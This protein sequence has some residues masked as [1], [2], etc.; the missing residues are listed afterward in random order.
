MK[1]LLLVSILALFAI[2]VLSQTRITVSKEYRDKGC[3]K[4][5]A[6]SETTNLSLESQMPGDEKNFYEYET[7]IIGNTYYD[8][9][10]N[11][12]SQNRMFLYPDGFIGGTFTLG[13]DFPAFLSDRGTGYNKY[14]ADSWGPWPVARIEQDRCGWPCYAPWGS[15]GEIIVAHY[16]G[17]GT[18]G[19]VFSKRTTKGTGNW[20]QFDFT[21]PDGHALLW[22]RM[23]TSGADHETIHLMA[24]TTPIANGGTIYQGQDGALVYSRSSDGGITWD[25]ENVIINGLG[26]AYYNGFDGDTY[27]FAFPKG[28]TIAMLIGHDWTD[29]ILMKSTDNGNSWTKTLVWEHPYPLFDPNNMIVTDT[30]YCADGSHSIALD[31]SGKVHIA[32]GINRA[33]CDGSIQYWFPLVDG[34]GYWNED[35]PVFSNNLNALSPYGDPGSELIEDYNLIGW[36]QDINGDGVLDILDDVAAYYM[37]PSSMPQLVTDDQYRIFLLYSS[38]TELYDQGSQNYRHIWARG[39]NDNGLSWGDFIDLNSDLI[40]IFDECVFPSCS[41]TTD[42]NI[43]F[44]YQGDNEPGLAVRGDLDP[45]GENYIYH[46][47]IEKAD[48]IIP[49]PG[50]TLTGMVTMLDGGA[51]VQGA[52]ISIEGTSFAA[53]SSSDGT[54]TIYNIPSGT[55]TVDCSKFGYVSLSA[56]VVINDDNTTY[57]NFQLEE[58]VVPE[59]GIIGNTIY[60][61]QSNASMQNRIYKYDDGTIGAVWTMGLDQFSFPDLGTGYNFYNGSEWLPAPVVSLENDRAGWPSYTR[62]GTAGEIV[63]SHY[64]GGASDGLVISSRPDKG[65][66]E[67]TMTNYYGPPN[68]GGYL[69]PRAVAGGNDHSDLHLIALTKPVII[70]GVIYEN[71]NGAL[72]YSRS[73]DGGLTWDHQDVLPEEI[74]S[75][76]YTGFRA[77]IYEITAIDSTVAFLIGDEY[78]DLILMKSTDNGDTWTK[79]IIWEHPYPMFDPYNQTPTDTFY[80]ADGAHSL[81]IDGSGK[82]HV[83]FGI[84]RTYSDG[85]STHLFDEVDGI[86]YWN[87]DMTTFSNNLNALSPYGDP[88]SELIQNYNLIAWSQDINGNGQLDFLDDWGDYGLGVSS[89][90][91]LIIDEGNNRYLIFSSVTEGYSTDDQNYRHL[92]VR[93]FSYTNQ[94][95]GDFL[96]L[97]QD[98]IYLFSECVFPSCSPTSDDQ[99]HLIFMEDSEPGMAVKG[100][101]DPYGLNNIMYMNVLKT[102]IL[103][104]LDFGILAGTVT[105]WGSG[106]PVSGASITIQGTAFLA[107][108]N[109]DGS[110][111][112]TGIPSGTYTVV[113]EKTGYNTETVVVEI[114]GN[115]TTTYNFQLVEPMPPMEEQVGQTWYDLQSNASMQNRIYKYDDGTIGAVWTMGFDFPSFMDRGT[116]YNYYD[117]ANWG[118]FP[119]DGI[120]PDRTGWPSYAPWGPNGE[121]VVAH[122]S[123]ASTDGLVISSR[124]NKGTGVWSGVDFYGPGSYN[125]Y[126]WPRAITGGNNHND[127]HIIAL[128]VPVANGGSL[129]QGMDG[130]LLYSRSPD[131]GLTWDHQ[132]VLLDEINSNYYFGFSGDTYE[133]QTQGNNVAFLVGDEWTDLVLMKS[134]DNG[135]T[136][137]KTVIWEHPYP[138]YD[139]G[140]SIPTDTF[141][142]VD[143]SHTLAFDQSGKIHVAFGINRAY[144]DGSGTFLFPSVD[145]IGYWNEDRP[146]FSSNLN[147]LSPYGD[148]GSELIPDYSLIGWSPDINGNGQL[149]VLDDWGTYYRGFSSMPQLVIDEMNDI[150]LVYSSV[151][152]GYDNG[153]QNYRHLW[154]RGSSDDGQSWGEFFHVNNDLIYIFSECVFPSLSPTTD[155]SI[156]FLFQ[157]DWE[158]GLAVIGDYD[159]YNENRIVYMNILKSDIITPSQ[160]GNITGTVTDAAGGFPVENATVSLSGTGFSATTGA[161]GNYIISSIPSGDYTAVCSKMGYFNVSYDVTIVEDT[162]TTQD[163]E[164]EEATGLEPPE[165]LI[166]TVFDQNNVLLE[167]DP[168]L[169]GTPL[170]YKIYRDYLFLAYTTQTTYTDE[171]LEPGTYEYFVTSVYETGESDPTDIFPVNIPEPCY[172]PENVTATIINITE[173]LLTWDPPVLGSPFG[174]NIYRDGTLLA[175]TGLT[176]IYF[177]DLAPGDYEFCV[178]SVCEEGESEPACAD[179]VTIVLLP[180]VNLVAE[181]TGPDVIL[182]WDEPQKKSLTGYNVYHN[183][184]NGNFSLFTYVTQTTCMYA[185]ASVGLH[186]FYVTAVYDQGESAHSDTVEVVITSVNNNFLQGITIHPNPA[187][188]F[189]NIKSGFIIKSVKVY[190]HTGKVIATEIV[191]NKFYKFNTSQFSQGLYFFRIE[192]SEGT[193]SKRIIIK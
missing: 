4:V 63:V 38:V 170:G 56:T 21:G 99:V 11:A 163:F 148:P 155:S 180:P 159:P 35:M 149:D 32:F 144:S 110:Y 100:D 114:I 111:E 46:Y 2:G 62:W 74:N 25:I 91:Q 117:G 133:I 12:G 145:G 72:L 129:Y 7:Q 107:Y 23:I 108:S 136:W 186:N 55:Y 124:P 187:S 58:I 156:H 150:F 40:Y 1:K 26:S 131:G 158:P 95:W 179:T 185:D 106:N 182:T 45:F 130:A 97:N 134:S 42:E 8:L 94:A 24:L 93:G 169:T 17:T 98:L 103:P 104:E 68:S 77:D 76:Y 175:F 18:D 54:Y 162:I 6:V 151:T 112:I 37:G 119:D 173:I 90:P 34:V 85:N 14:V 132:D 92:W 165:N 139:P 5:P 161:D 101:L 39:S 29:L 128:T 168:P 50:N 88:G 49:D 188:G 115:N 174:F 177:D 43:H 140:A 181:I 121:I 41:P 102:D 79:T 116:G 96:D 191:N 10:T 51:P 67:W 82:I 189:V 33:V 44:L 53:T 176:E 61:L 19:L 167:W 122:Y 157:E 16:S 57:Q 138:F 118:P 66:G 125:Y 71:M 64:T 152:E 27:E 22:P 153:L 164:L 73:P 120:E 183:I 9:Q 192:T 69:W 147:A 13:F 70:G 135:D 65:N 36:M 52:G 47:S 123:G 143:G 113:C 3:Q 81:C 178:S 109:T 137:T 59:D 60:D 30:F 28:D 160:G 166:A 89:M 142:N 172:P 15:N 86:A 141:Y 48:I 80:C 75:D 84:T 146:T 31:N 154:A 87:E 184:N 83:A 126:L 171:G 190:D 20:T 193:I 78:C 127:L 105:E